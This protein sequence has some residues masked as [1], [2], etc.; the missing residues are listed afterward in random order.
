VWCDGTNV[1]PTSLP[2]DD[3]GN[4]PADQIS[5]DAIDG[6]TISNFASTGIDDN[7][8][9]TTITIDSSDNVSV[10]PGTPTTKL[11]V[12]GP[13]N[14][15]ISV[16][17]TFGDGFPGFQLLSDGVLAGQVQADNSDGKLQIQSRNSGPIVFEGDGPTELARLTQDK[18]FGIDTTNPQ[19]RLHITDTDPTIRLDDDRTE[20]NSGSVVVG[21]AAMRF[22]VDESNVTNGSS[23]RWKKDGTEVMRIDDT[24]S[25]NPRLTFVNDNNIV[26]RDAILL[27]SGNMSAPNVNNTQG[28]ILND[29]SGNQGVFTLDNAGTFYIESLNGEVKARDSNGNET[30]ISPHNFSLIPGGPSEEMAWAYYSRR[31]NTAVNCDMMAVVREVEKLTGKTFIYQEEV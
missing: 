21:L 28:I 4:L 19:V 30:T 25:G 18:N 2:L 17:D 10:G 27:V 16:N 26:D 9:S 13:P 6:G 29:E 20:S 8:S 1:E 14:P 11:Q 5:G 22:E 3:S 7:A 15:K 23:F 31:G 24:S 12:Q